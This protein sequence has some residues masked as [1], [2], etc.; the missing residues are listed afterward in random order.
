MKK[1]FFGRLLLISFLLVVPVAFAISTTTQVQFNVAEVVAYTLTLPG[2]TAVAGNATAAA[3]TAIEFNSSGTDNFVAARVFGGT[4]QSEGVPIFSFDNTGTVDLNISV[5]LNSAIPTC[6]NLTGSNLSS[7]AA[8][9][10]SLIA[11]GTAIN[12]N[13]TIINQMT[14]AAAAQPWYMVTSFNAC[15][16]NDTTTRTMFSHGIRAS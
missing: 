4:Q 3:T 2:E 1:R 16:L 9:N 7:S 10:G 5:H 8:A 15:V 14:P 11:N 13:V 12:A 6:M